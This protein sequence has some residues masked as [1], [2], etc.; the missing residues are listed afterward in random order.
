MPDFSLP[1]FGLRNNTFTRVDVAFTFGGKQGVWLRVIEE[2]KLSTLLYCLKSTKK[3]ITNYMYDDYSNAGSPQIDVA[4]ISSGPT[5][6]DFKS[7]HYWISFVTN[8][9]LLSETSLRSY[10]ETA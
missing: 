7:F 6:A 5:R 2:E 4:F 8:R 3:I 1:T 10:A 9:E